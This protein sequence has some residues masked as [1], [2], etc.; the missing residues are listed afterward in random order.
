VRVKTWV[1]VG[2]VGVLG[3]CASAGAAERAAPPVT[4]KS[5]PSATPSPGAPKPITY[6]VE[7]SGTWRVAGGSSAVAGRSGRLM[8]YRVAVEKDI[9]IDVDQFA[10]R[11]TAVLADP[12]SWTAGG[13]WRLQRVGPGQPSDFTVYLATPATRDR[14]C[15]MGYDRY[16]SCR[17]GEKVVLN[18]ARWAHGIPKYNLDTYRIYMVNHETGHRLGHGH[19]QCPGH[20]MPAPVMQQQTL[21]MHGCTPNP[22]PYLDGR[23][24][25]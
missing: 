5:S 24:Y 9:S 15:A 20:G 7:G 11:V 13:S 8:R 14:L 4:V 18:V 21:G 12:R 19:E 23:L 6:P 16:T 3:G 22:W 1:L 2:V 17:N 25:P 10:Q